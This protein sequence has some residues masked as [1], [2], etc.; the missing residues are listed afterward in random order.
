VRTGGGTNH[1]FGLSSGVLI[2]DNHIAAAR[3][4]GVTSIAAIISQARRAA[5]HTMRIEVEVTSL[6]ELLDAL[7]GSP[8]IILLDNM[9]VDD[10]RRAVE[11]IGGRAVVE[12]SGG[13]T[14]ENVRG[15]A[16]AGVDLISVG[17]LTHSAPALDISLELAP[18]L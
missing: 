16:E 3:E 4:Q 9:S 10:M 18:L 17:A 11:T 5:P 8:E 13:V 15:I 6:E 14:L 2:K 7:D 12:A 1:R